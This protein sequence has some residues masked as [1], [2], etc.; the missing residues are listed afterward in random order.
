M[1]L[2][3]TLMWCALHKFRGFKFLFDK[4][5]LKGADDLFV[6]YLCNC[7]SSVSWWLIFNER[8]TFFDFQSFL[9]FYQI[10]GVALIIDLYSSSFT[11]LLIICTW[12]LF[13][14]LLS[15][16]LTKQH[17]LVL[18]GSYHHHHIHHHH[19]DAH[20]RKFANTVLVANHELL[21]F[22]RQLHALTHLGLLSLANCEFRNKPSSSITLI[23]KQWRNGSLP[24]FL[25]KQCQAIN[26]NCHILC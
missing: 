16:S 1:L 18:V 14:I 12:H 21:Q 10:S 17:W 25:S 9:F 19:Q 23:W 22:R 3:N 15:Y 11:A 7:V 26:S 5:P 13:Q 20:L 6:V 2:K 8:S 4:W 24:S